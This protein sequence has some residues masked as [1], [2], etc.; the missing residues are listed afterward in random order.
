MDII[1]ESDL[2]RS[3]PR[4]QCGHR[5]GAEMVEEDLMWDSLYL[6]RS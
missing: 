5:R 2:E 3:I 1:I 6:G 4:S